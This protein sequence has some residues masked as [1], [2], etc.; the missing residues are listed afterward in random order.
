MAKREEYVEY[1]GPIEHRK[2]KTAVAYKTEKGLRVQF[3]RSRSTGGG[4]SW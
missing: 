1:G 3:V 2:G 4:E